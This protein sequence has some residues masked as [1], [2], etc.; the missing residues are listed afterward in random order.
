[1]RAAPRGVDQTLAIES[2]QFFR[3][4][5]TSQPRKSAIIGHLEQTMAIEMAQPRPAA[6][7]ESN[8]A[9]GDGVP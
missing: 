9:D 3:G 7:R 5:G 6:L 4:S 2:A 8:W 1:M